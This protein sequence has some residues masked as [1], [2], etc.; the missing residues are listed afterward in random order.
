MYNVIQ[1]LLL[2]IKY[3]KLKK[4]LPGSCG[5]WMWGS[6]LKLARLWEGRSGVRTRAMHVNGCKLL[7]LLIWP[8]T[9]LSNWMATSVEVEEKRCWN[10]SC[11]TQEWF[12]GGPVNTDLQIWQVWLITFLPPPT[13]PWNIWGWPGE[14]MVGNSFPGEL[15][16][17]VGWKGW[18]S[19]KEF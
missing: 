8:I 2:P 16:C 7:L 3:L 4:V 1:L 9:C 5:V 11:G 14:E 18:T 19:F 17:W 15:L 10:D 12:L 13:P 6:K